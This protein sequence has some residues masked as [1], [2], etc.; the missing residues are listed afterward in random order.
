[1]CFSAEASFAAAAVL[2][3]TGAASVHR[4]YRTDRRYMALGALPF[5][6]GIQQ[7][8]EGLVWTAGRH[9]RPDL[10]QSFSLAYMFFAWLA[11]PVWVPLSVYLVE[12]DSKKKIIYLV[13]CIF[14]SM[15]GAIQYFPYFAHYGWLVVR[16]LD[17]AIN[18]GG[19][20]LSD[21][22]WG[23]EITYLTYVS[24]VAAP[25]LLASDRG[26]AVFG[27][28]ILVVLLTTFLFFR[29]AYISVFCFGSALMSLYIVFLTFK[30]TGLSVGS[31]V[32]PA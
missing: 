20:E 23:R 30:R 7:L 16:F 22:L 4:A 26:I 15:L 32:R 17:Y 1:M 8:L 27:L 5:L 13:F 31:R 25:L 12:P 19:L 2:L 21:F 11:W 6:F 14:G 24:L 9:E 29:Y 3:P 18:Y 28:L 10:V